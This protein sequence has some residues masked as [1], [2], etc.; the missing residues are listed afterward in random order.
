VLSN[1]G[2]AKSEDRTSRSNVRPNDA[3]D[4]CYGE[5]AAECWSSFGRAGLLR[6]LAIGENLFFQGDEALSAHVLRDGWAFRYQ[7]LEDGRRQIV[8]FVLPGD[9]IGVD[10]S[11]RMA[12]GVEALSICS[13]V[14]VSRERF[15]AL[16]CDQ[17]VLSINLMGQ[18]LAG[19][20]RAFEQVTSVGRRTARERVACLL[21][22]LARR[23][24]KQGA[25]CEGTEIGMPLTQLH[26]GDAL[27]LA[28]ETVCRSLGELKSDGLLQF[29]AGRL[30][31]SQMEKLAELAGI[32]L[33]GRGEWKADCGSRGGDRSWQASA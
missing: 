19:Q 14:S 32:S 4:A 31:I 7:S 12:Y 25:R 11:P 21:L 27:G 2:N 13:W 24:T 3:S 5:A 22:D 20:V 6:S 23:S 30:K 15:H 10:R 9:L 1:K 26:I 8:D 18:I 29:S 33:D 28:A 17:P 16:L